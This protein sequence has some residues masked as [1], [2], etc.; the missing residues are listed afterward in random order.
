[1]DGG[2]KSNGWKWYKAV[3][4]RSGNEVVYGGYGVGPK[5]SYLLL[6]K[7]SASD[8]TS[9]KKDYDNWYESISVF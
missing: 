8:S 4:A 5:G 1:V 3:E 7:T 2:G 9:N 6:L